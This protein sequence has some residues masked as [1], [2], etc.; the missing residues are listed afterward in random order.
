VVDSAC[1]SALARAAVETV[2][3]AATSL[4]K[5]AKPFADLSVL[6]TAREV[7]IEFHG[8]PTWKNVTPGPRLDPALL[9]RARTELRA[10]STMLVDAAR[11]LHALHGELAALASHPGRATLADTRAKVSR[12]IAAIAA[13]TH[14]PLDHA[15]RESISAVET[16]VLDEIVA[17]RDRLCTD[18]QRD[19]AT[20]AAC[21]KRQAL[22]EAH[23]FLLTNGRPLRKAYDEAFQSLADGLGRLVDADARVEIDRA[24][25]RGPSFGEPCGPRGLC[26]WDHAC[27]AATRTCEK[28]CFTMAMSP[29]PGSMPC[30]EVPGLDGTYCRKRPATRT[31]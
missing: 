5:A 29:C 18:R 1:K 14:A 3:R 6:E 24:V 10:L 15:I 7:E 8:L 30:V 12:E 21:D 23:S 26:Q 27:Q 11:R 13:L 19:P 22:H 31:P 17:L 20:R 28:R 2:E 25:G 9:A 16:R 4:D